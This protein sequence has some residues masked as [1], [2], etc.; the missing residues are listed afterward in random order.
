M[1][2]WKW[3]RWLYSITHSWASVTTV[4]YKCKD[5]SPRDITAFCE[6]AV[7]SPEIVGWLSGHL[8]ACSSSQAFVFQWGPSDGFLSRSSGL[9]KPHSS[10]ASNNVQ[11]SMLSDGQVASSSSRFRRRQ[12]EYLHSSTTV[13]HL[14]NV[15]NYVATTWPL[16]TVETAPFK[17][18]EHY[19]CVKFNIYLGVTYRFYIINLIQ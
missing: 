7:C 9:C 8:L 3:L 13:W 12:F 5:S 17:H 2:C 18:V 15:L 14:L 19:L 4:P 10:S 11:Y 6:S 1:P 16:C